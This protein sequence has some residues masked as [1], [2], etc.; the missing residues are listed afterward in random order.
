MAW[1]CKHFNSSWITRLTIY[2]LVFTMLSIL[3]PY[4]LIFA[5]PLYSRAWL[6]T[7]GPGLICRS[8]FKQLVTNAACT[9]RLLLEADLVI[10]SNAKQLP[11]QLHVTQNCSDSPMVLRLFIFII[12]SFSHHLTRFRH[13]SDSFIYWN[14]L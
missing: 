2:S 7:F 13:L 3:A 14:I 8:G 5:V 6:Y 1:V 10:I 9:I 11:T 12:I 4:H